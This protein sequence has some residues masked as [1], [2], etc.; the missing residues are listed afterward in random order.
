[1]AWTLRTAVV[2]FPTTQWRPRA[3]ATRPL[4]G[5]QQ[6]A[7]RVV[8]AALAGGCYPR[9]RSLAGWRRSGGSPRHVLCAPIAKEKK[10]CIANY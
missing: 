10:K 1:M 2:T 7:G 8:Y 3:A 5:S 6:P 4:A 9:M